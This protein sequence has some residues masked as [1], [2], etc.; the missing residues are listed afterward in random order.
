MTLR[1]PVC[2]SGLGI[3]GL[4][5][6]VSMPLAL[7][8]TGQSRER[9]DLPREV[10]YYGKEEA[11]PEQVPLVRGRSRWSTKLAIC[12]TSNWVTAKWCGNGEP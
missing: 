10:L 8:A 12:V 7:D 9:R 6:A 2:R 1:S 4:L 5:A 3:V 11:L